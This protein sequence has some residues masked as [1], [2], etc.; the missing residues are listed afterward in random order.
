M[1]SHLQ[2][3]TALQD[4]DSGSTADDTDPGPMDGLGREDGQLIH[5]HQHQHQHT[6]KQV[7]KCEKSLCKSSCWKI[8]QP[9]RCYATEDTVLLSTPHV[10]HKT[11]STLA[12][13]KKEAGARA[14]MNKAVR[15][16]SVKRMYC[17]S[18]CYLLSRMR[19]VLLRTAVASAECARLGIAPASHILSRLPSNRMSL[20]HALLNPASAKALSAGLSSN[21]CIRS[22]NLGR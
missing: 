18:L 17:K 6:G 2:L 5:Q 10:A 21:R 9:K 16:S 14:Q 20:R 1:P 11:S 15:D 13:L 22:L 7:Y 12:A 3:E 4:E 8:C 19:W